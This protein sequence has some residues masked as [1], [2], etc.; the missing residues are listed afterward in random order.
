MMKGQRMN[1]LVAPTAFMME[2]S[3]RRLYMVTRTVFA[4]MNRDTASSMMM[5]PTL[6]MVTALESCRTCSARSE[7]PRTLATWLMD[8]RLS[9]TVS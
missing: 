2:I 7:L 6:M 1:Q 9:W 4:M 3:R 8:L 5:I